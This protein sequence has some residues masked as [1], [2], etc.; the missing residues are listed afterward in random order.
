MRVLLQRVL[1]AEVT[2]GGLSCGKIGAGLLAL[3]GVG[4]GDGPDDA[5][6]CARK[7]LNLRLHSDA[8]S[9]KQWSASVGSRGLGLLL[10]SQFTLHASC[11]KTKPSFS[12]ALG[13][14]EAR[15]LFDEVVH[16]CREAKNVD[17][18]TGQ[19]GA[20]MEV[21]LV[22]DGPVTVWLDSKNRNDLAW[23]AAVGADDASGD[24]GNE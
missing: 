22:N 24:V 23:G 10:V 4:E 21:G 9:G 14:D 19:F 20:M 6:W 5:A 8:G 2:V 3:V 15:A 7:M 13:G 12:R 17:V 11:R 1:R 16:L 18:Q